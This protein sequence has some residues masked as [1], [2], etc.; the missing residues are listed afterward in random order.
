MDMTLIDITPLP[1]VKRE[2]EVVLIGKQGS[3]EITAADVADWQ[4]TIPY[5][6]LCSMGTRAHR[7][8]E[9]L[10]GQP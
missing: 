7:M 6:V 4:D 10:T 2:D 8:Y 5:E 9:P 3:D 1:W